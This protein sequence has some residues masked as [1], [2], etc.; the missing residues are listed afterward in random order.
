MQPIKL[1]V[2]G[3]TDIGQARK[4]NEDS[5]HWH[6]DLELPFAYAIVADGMGGYS[7]GAM[8]SNLAIETF[9]HHLDKQ[10]NNTFLSCSPEQQQLILR[11]TLVDA[12]KLANQQILNAKN[13][14]P[15]FSKM[16]T[17]FVLAV[18]WRNFLIVA[19][20]GDSRA[21]LWNQYGLRPLTQDHS[22][23]Q[24]MINNGQ[25]SPQEA[26]TSN[27]RNHIT[28][29]LGVTEQVDPAINSWPLTDNA[30]LLLCSDGLT[31]YLN[32][33]D[34]E[35]ILSTHRPA[36]ECVYRFIDDANQMGGKDNVSACILEFS[37]QHNV[38]PI[39]PPT[40]E[41]PTN[42]PKHDATIRKEQRNISQI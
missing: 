14:N 25:L 22:I 27:L 36:L 6:S 24:E 35:L 9:K 38:P 41:H 13:S 3:R 17:T 8:A 23:V 16:G 4:E 28:R 29:A 15:Q 10:L 37:T 1:A 32:D 2:N 18:V 12:I 20:L 31:E 39:A 19:H 30:L 33:R 40:P 42:P 21:Y 11:A 26:R 34:L 5:I 7:G